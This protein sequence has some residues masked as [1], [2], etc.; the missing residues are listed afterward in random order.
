M[1]NDVL[2]AAG[3]V[4]P[5]IVYVGVRLMGISLPDWVAI[6]TL[7]YIGLQVAN[8]LWRWRRAARRPW[9]SDL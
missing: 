5:P 2:Q 3:K 8:L 9:A 7:L 6:M 4:S 1:T